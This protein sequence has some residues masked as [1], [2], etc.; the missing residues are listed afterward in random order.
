MRSA[1]MIYISKY[2]YT[3]LEEWKIYSVKILALFRNKRA[4]IVITIYII[5]IG[6]QCFFFFSFFHRISTTKV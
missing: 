2:M 3:Y 1:K 4:K 6:L 5:R